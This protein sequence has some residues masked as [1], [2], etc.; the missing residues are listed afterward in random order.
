MFLL[1][2]AA[3][4]T[5][6]FGTN[7]NLPPLSKYGRV[8]GTVVNG[9]VG[10]P[11]KEVRLL[12]DVHGTIYSTTT[13]TDG[14][15]SLDTGEI[16]RG[17]GFTLQVVHGS[18]DTA[19]RA[20]VFDVV[21]LRVDLGTIALTETGSAPE[22]TRTVTGQV[23]DYNGTALEGAVISMQNSATP[24]G[25][26]HGVTA[27]D[28]SFSL[29]G[30][31]LYTGSTYSLTV[32][33]NGH[34]SKSNVTAAV[35]GTTSIIDDNPVYL[36]PNHGSI[37]GTVL[38][39][40]TGN[41]LAGAAVSADDESGN[42]ISGTTDSEGKFRLENDH[43]YIEHTYSVSITKNLYRTGS[44]TATID[45][46]D[47]NT[48]TGG[49]LELLIDSSIT[50]TVTGSGGAP[51]ADVTVSTIDSSGSTVTG[52]S[53]TSGIF[54]INGEHF[55]KNQAYTLTFTHDDHETRSFDT[56]TIVPGS[57]DT[58]TIVLVEKSYDYILTGTVEDAWDTGAKV[59]AAISIIDDYGVERTATC[60]G[61][62]GAFSVGGYF[63]KDSTYSLAVSCAGYT[64]NTSV[65]GESLG[66]TITGDMPQSEH[67]AVGTILLYPIGI[68]TRIQGV[69]HE[70][71]YELKESRE[72][73]LTGK[74]GF[75]LSGRSGT[76]RNSYSS[77]YVHTDDADQVP[78]PPGG[79]RSVAIRIN[80]TAG[81]AL[82]NGVA[83]EESSRTAV[84]KP[85]AF[86]IRT[87]SMYHFKVTDPGSVT[88]ET[89]G[90]TDTSLILYFENGSQL[91]ADDNSGSGS[92]GSI[93][94]NTA[95]TGAGWYFVKVSGANDSVWGTFS[96]SI[97]GPEQTDGSVGTWTLEDIILSW[98]SDTDRVMYIAGKNESPSTGTIT[99]S[100]M[101]NTGG[102]VRGSFS[103]SLRAIT[104][105]GA[106][107]TAADGYFNIIRSQ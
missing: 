61:T 35:S 76:D 99:I 49:T 74:H 9:A 2:V 40:T 106:T 51:V 102:L 65:T 82:V 13:E 15:F 90:D 78:A 30:T 91:A 14:T 81:G 17:E 80:G 100:T 11:V 52:V 59:A 71:S 94:F 43:F 3:M 4:L 46:L 33:K 42:T 27:A 68:R 88:I 55:R 89:T 87:Y 105:G 28:G 83:G 93:T 6:C 97:S 23:V 37:T 96:L 101:E 66:V 104:S 70:F 29:S 10:D 107:V 12:M 73:F 31:Y 63:L 85:S 54:T 86:K 47:D 39:D 95:A 1:S 20:V 84:Q 34:I 62:T 58:G 38:D 44:V 5:G 103:G 67:Q 16:T 64:G 8:T 36:F 48:I 32:S 50:G 7:S 22:E 69:K 41:P 56:S 18:F 45:S 19:S 92:N 72:K 24:T 98:Y 26:I 57:N 75:T 53:D 60:D 21:N 77:F 79:G 25:T